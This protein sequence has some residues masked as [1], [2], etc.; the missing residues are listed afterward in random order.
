MPRSS[1]R[2][3]RSTGPKGVRAAGILLIAWTAAC[4]SSETTPARSAPHSSSSR[5]ATRPLPGTVSDADDVAKRMSPKFRECYQIG[6]WQNADQ[7]GS[8]RLVIAIDGNGRPARVTPDG[9]D[10][11]DR[12]VLSCLVS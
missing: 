6:L 2:A 4:G 8:V 1:R 12:M 11:L 10:G 9:G 7:K 5:A 3:P